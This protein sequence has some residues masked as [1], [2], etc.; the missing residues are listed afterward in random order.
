M[1]L[2]VAQGLRLLLCL[3]SL[4]YLVFCGCL[5]LLLRLLRRF[6]GLLTGIGFVLLRLRCFFGFLDLLCRLRGLPAELTCAVAFAASGCGARFLRAGI[7][8]HG[9]ILYY[10]FDHILSAGDNRHGHVRH[11]TVY[12]R[13]AVIRKGRPAAQSQ[14]A[15]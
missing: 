3:R 12:R 5:R 2:L 14:C 11:G 4:L 9:N 1:R 6:C 10:G 13:R 7:G 15:Q 8:G